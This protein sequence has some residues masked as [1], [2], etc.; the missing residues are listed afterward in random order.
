MNKQMEQIHALNLAFAAAEH[1]LIN[2]ISA[3]TQREQEIAAELRGLKQRSELEKVELA[4]SQ[5]EQKHVLHSQYAER[6]K[7]L[8]EQLQVGQ[9][10]LERLL[11]ERAQRDHDHAE[12]TL[13]AKN[14]L[15]NLTHS[16]AQREQEIATQ[17]R[18]LQ[19]QREQER[20][21]LARS[22]NEQEHVLHCKYAE[23]EKEFTEKLQTAQQEFLRLQQKLAQH[24]RMHAEQV[25][26]AKQQQDSLAHNL[27]Q[28]VQEVAAQMQA[29]QQ[30]GEYEKAAMARHHS[31][32]ERAWHS[33]H[34]EREKAFRQQ[35]Q[36]AQDELQTLRQELTQQDKDHVLQAH[37]SQQELD[38]LLRLQVQR[39]QEVT[40]QIV[41]LHKQAGQERVLLARS[42]DEQTRIQR[43]DQVEREKALNHQLQSGQLELQRL[44]QERAQREKD[45]ADQ[46][47][48]ARQKLEN[49]LR[50]QVQREQQVTTQLL[51]LEQEKNQQ[52][53]KHSEQAN[54]LRSRH[55]EREQVL[56]QQLQAGQKELREKLEHANQSSL[57][58]ESL[59]SQHTKRE[60]EIGAQLLDMHKQAQYAN[61]NHAKLLKEC[62]DLQ[63]RLQ[64]EIQSGQLNS[65]HLHELLAEMQHRLDTMHSSLSWRMSAPL[66][67]LATFLS[68][69]RNHLYAPVG[70]DIPIA[71]EADALTTLEAP[72]AATTQE[73]IE[74]NMSIL[75]PETAKTMPTIASTL[76]E[77]L[78][79]ND[80]QFVQCAY[81]TL[82]GREPDSEGMGYYLTRLRSGFRKIEILAQLKSSSEGKSQE[83]TIPDLEKFVAQ[84]QRERYPLV[85]WIF[86]A[87][88]NIQGKKSI[89]QE[90]RSIGNKIFLMQ[91]E[92]DKRFDKLEHQIALNT[93]Q[94][95]IAIQS[96][97]YRQ[98]IAQSNKLNTSSELTHVK[99]TKP[100]NG[101]IQPPLDATSLMLNIKDEISRRN[102]S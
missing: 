82:L 76:P 94:I 24:D 39:E 84:Y 45:H 66:R 70:L 19:Q 101:S 32:Q 18:D 2:E 43:E 22:Q 28:R 12:Q 42:Y 15:E 51:A 93:N 5:N 69:R 46:T 81:R 7:A 25:L 17:L 83:S 80:Q 71:S 52:A 77:L 99:N 98:N 63:A 57:A 20:S 47:C 92:F 87:F 35:L 4:H 36:S 10:E 9:R 56:G 61:E 38:T 65:R 59:I 21:E 30:Y 88:N 16:L 95:T 26:E 60:Q 73:S 96:N 13:Q 27:N 89:E 55:A 74:L 79:H 37:R 49:Q 72:P 40:A 34:S 53:R 58:L 48:Q 86:K 41:A 3:L 33:Q 50:H 54:I 11:Q 102:K 31:E 91:Q 14:A 8:A 90:I 64:A 68:P 100:I 67:K 97:A 75:A 44:R 85:G 29:L 78:S 6:E 23:R 1:K 62:S